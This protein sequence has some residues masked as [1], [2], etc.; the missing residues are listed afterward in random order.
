MAVLNKEGKDFEAVKPEDSVP[1]NITVRTEH[2]NLS[3]VKGKNRIPILRDIN[4][5][6]RQGEKWG[7]AGESGAGKSMTMYALTSLLPEKSMEMTGSIFYREPDGSETDLLKMPYK[8][9]HLYCSEKASLIL[10]DSINALNPFEKI[11]KQWGETIRLHSRKELG[12]E[13]IQERILQ[14]MERFGLSG[15]REVLKKY[16][17]QLSGGM[18]QRIA[19]AMALESNSKLLIADEPT[20]SLDAINQR[21]IITFIDELCDKNKLTLLYISHNLGIVQDL[22]THVAV[23]KDGWIIEQGR[24]ED[25]FYS[26]KEAYTKKLIEETLR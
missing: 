25:V 26:P 16:P 21:K 8:D 3:V 1:H 10:Q 6:V 23:M 17:H 24:M 9:R 15:G 4:L 14:Q 22:C 5:T 12:K 19:I 11:E 7:I 20:T 2:L 13:E 18:R